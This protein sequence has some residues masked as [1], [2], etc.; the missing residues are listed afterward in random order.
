MTNAP[1][2]AYAAP[3][4]AILGSLVEI[5]ESGDRPNADTPR[6]NDGTAFKPGS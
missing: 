5:T 3:A 4:V 2:K 1:K 6:G